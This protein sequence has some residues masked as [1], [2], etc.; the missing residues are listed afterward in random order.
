[1]TEERA[2]GSKMLLEYK[3]IPKVQWGVT[4]TGKVRHAS[5]VDETE[6]PQTYQG[7]SSFSTT[8]DS[9]CGMYIRRATYMIAE[10]KVK[11]LPVC[12]TCQR[13]YRSL[14]NQIWKMNI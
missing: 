7:Y 9:I 10:Y 5:F 6:E 11:E 14:A 8:Y 2:V 3:S 12:Q 13:S 4:Y 1:M